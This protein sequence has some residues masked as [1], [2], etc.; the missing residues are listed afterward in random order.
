[1]EVHWAISC[2][3]ETLFV[4]AADGLHI[5]M[6]LGI[7]PAFLHTWLLCIARLVEL[8]WPGNGAKGHNVHEVLC[9]GIV[10]D[11]SCRAGYSALYHA[12]FTSL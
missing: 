11:R 12:V 3:N 4:P 1:M 7:F 10:C 5:Q 2:C 8:Y 9:D 6:C